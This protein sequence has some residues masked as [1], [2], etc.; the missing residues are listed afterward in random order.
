MQ[1]RE[2]TF[3]GFGGVELFCQR[4]R[5]EGEPR[6]A[7]AIVHGF[8]EHSG[9]YANVVGH[10]VPRGFAV[11]G[12]DLRGFG[13]SPGRRGHVGSWSEH[14][15]DAA[16]FLRKVG[17]DEPGRPL[18]LMGHSMGGL[19]ALDYVLRRPE[20]LAGA[21]ASGPGLEP[22]GVAK[23]YLVALAR[24]LSRIWPRFSLDVGLDASAVSRDP[25]VVRAFLDDPLRNPRGTVRWGTE[26]LAAIAWIKAHAGE[27]KVPLLM[28]HGGDDR[29]VSPEGSR[30]FFAKVTHPDK[31]LH[32]YDG[33]Y[34]EPHND[35]GHE[36]VLADL[37]DWLER[38]LR[39]TGEPE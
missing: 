38:H 12:Y 9:R 22:V 37:G 31:E 1:H 16:A 3:Q 20:G 8:A 2:G 34:H 11:Y 14:R 32:V 7:L 15:E 10:L 6:A 39:R 30:R 26:V 25:E 13:R 19:I 36:K 27:M 18:F 28:V 5:P 4:W 29:L 21:I 35:L 24:L 17:G 33:V 23:P